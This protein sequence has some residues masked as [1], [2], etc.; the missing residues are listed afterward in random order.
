MM[1]YPRIRLLT[2][3][4]ENFRLAKIKPDFLSWCVGLKIFFQNFKMLSSSDWLN[5]FWC[6]INVFVTPKI[7]EKVLLSIYLFPFTCWSHKKKQSFIVKLKSTLTWPLPFADRRLFS[8]RTPRGDICLA[9]AISNFLS[10]CQCCLS[11]NQRLASNQFRM[12]TLTININ[13]RSFR[14]GGV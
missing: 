12:S 8:P 6:I 5:G 1:D 13:Y 14:F 7:R 11:A 9:F 3:R 2:F 10:C 4:T